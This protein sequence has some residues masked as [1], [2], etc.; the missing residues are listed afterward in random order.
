MQFFL[1]DAEPAVIDDRD[2]KKIEKVEIEKPTP[3]ENKQILKPKKVL[4][5]DFF[6]K[7]GMKSAPIF[8]MRTD[9]L[10]ENTNKSTF[11]HTYTIIWYLLNFASL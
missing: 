5:D 11:K 2:K 10:P 4:Y 9:M 8:S 3:I 1:K 7:P 6:W